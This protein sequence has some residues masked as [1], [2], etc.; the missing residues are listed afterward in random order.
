MILWGTPIKRLALLSARA[1]GPTTQENNTKRASASFKGHH[2]KKR[3]V[4]PSGGDEKAP[5]PDA[6]AGVDGGGADGLLD[7]PPQALSMTVLTGDFAMILGKKTFGIPG[8][9]RQ[10]WGLC[11]L[12]EERNCSGLAKSEHWCRPYPHCC[13]A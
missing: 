12:S 10:H 5:E 6:D 9:L 11:E 2:G 3:C 7:E 8:A 13:E 4:A 1:A